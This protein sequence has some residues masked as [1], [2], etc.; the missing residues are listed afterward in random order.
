MKKIK[1]FEDACKALGL[2]PSKLPDV[3]A[4]PE[5]HMN[6]IIAYFKLVIIAEAL[7][8]GWEPD[9]SDEDECKYYPWFWMDQPGS[10]FSYFGSD[11]SYSSSIVGS[12][13]CF[14]TRELAEYAGKQF[15]E[16]YQQYHLLNK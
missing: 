15:L 4:L 7:N 12:R 11:Y 8:Q 2:D 1:T 10:G 9:W 5:K 16:L 3:S 14:Q 6:S 13:L